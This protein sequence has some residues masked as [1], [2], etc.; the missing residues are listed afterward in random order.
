MPSQEDVPSTQALLN[1][2]DGE[3]TA[4]HRSQA[5]VHRG[6]GYDIHG[7][8]A[9]VLF[10]RQG[11]RDRDG[12]R[13]TYF[14]T[15]EN[16]DAD[17]LIVARYGTARV[18]ATRGT[19]TAAL[20]RPNASGGAGTFYKG[21][22]FSVISHS[23]M[24]PLTFQVS[25][26][27]AI[28]ASATQARV[29]IETIKAGASQAVSA[30]VGNDGFIIEDP[31]WDNN[32]RVTTLD[33]GAGTARES[34]DAYKARAKA[35]RQSQRKGYVEAITEACEAAGASEVALFPSDWTG[36]DHGVNHCFVADA[37]FTTPASLLTACRIAVDSARV[38]GAD[39]FVFG[40][41]NTPLT[42]SLTLQ[43]W[44]PEKTRSSQYLTELAQAA[45]VDYFASRENAFYWT[46]A[47]IRGAVLRQIR[48]DLQDVLVSSSLS[49]PDRA[50]MLDTA[51]LPRYVVTSDA[52]FVTV[53][54]PS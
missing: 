21:T 44:D 15:A 41:T 4:L 12:F 52:V 23:G 7:G 18:D 47:A 42:I 45:V 53:V 27:T 49:E 43:V 50:T 1:A 36:A 20:E 31:V 54:G 5:D 46:A 37:G 22:R 34:T 3:I 2:Y 26:D 25:S 11:L 40:M 33:C 10:H 28:G 8:V 51:I 38:L 9:G 14:D 48:G 16:D 29:P 6:S 39:L 30:A 24:P 35:L 13:A 32:W 17:T 19:G